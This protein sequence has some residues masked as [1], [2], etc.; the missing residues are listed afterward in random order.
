MEL[1][2]LV[3]QIVTFA[4]LV[5]A[6]PSLMKLLSGPARGEIETREHA[7]DPHKVVT[8][9]LPEWRSDAIR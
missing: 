7:L 5:A 6:Y 8:A 3:V 9:T 2:A 1:V 4:I